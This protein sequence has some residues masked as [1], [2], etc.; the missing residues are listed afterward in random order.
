[1]VAGALNITRVPADGALI[2]GNTSLLGSESVREVASNYVINATDISEAFY[3]KGKKYKLLKVLGK[4]PWQTGNESIDPEH[5]LRNIKLEVDPRG[6]RKV[7]NLFKIKR[8]KKYPNYVRKQRQIYREDLKKYQ[9]KHA[10]SAKAVAE[11]RDQPVFANFPS[12]TRPPATATPRGARVV[13][14]AAPRVVSTA[15]PRVVPKAAPR[16]ISSTPPRVV[17]KAAPRVGSTA[18]PRGGRVITAASVNKPG[19]ASPHQQSLQTSEKQDKPRILVAAPSPH[20]GRVVSTVTPNGYHYTTKSSFVDVQFGS[21]RHVYSTTHVPPAAQHSTLAPFHHA[22]AQHHSTTLAPIK[23]AAS[24]PQ[25]LSTL[26]PL[27]LAPSAHHHAPTPAPHPAHHSTTLAPLHVPQHHTTASPSHVP[28]H[29]S[30]GPAN[31]HST[32][33]A[34]MHVSHHDSIAPKQVHPSHLS[35]TH[36]PSP[37]STPAS[38]QPTTYHSKIV[39]LK[40]K[41]KEPPALPPYHPPTSIKKS[42]AVTKTVTTA[43]TTTLSTTETIVHSLPSNNKKLP[44]TYGSAS[45]TVHSLPPAPQVSP[46]LIISTSAPL[47]AQPEHTV[48]A[49]GPTTTVH[50]L[51]RLHH[52]SNTRSPSIAIGSKQH[53]DNLFLE[54]DQG[55]IKSLY[56][57][58]RNI[59]LVGPIAVRATGPKT[60]TI[61]DPQSLEHHHNI[62]KR[63]HKHS[64]NSLPAEKPKLTKRPSLHFEPLAKVRFEHPAR[65]DS[66]AKPVI[67]T[68]PKLGNKW[69]NDGVI[70]VLDGNRRWPKVKPTPRSSKL[71]LPTPRV[72]IGVDPRHSKH[73]RFEDLSKDGA[74]DSSSTFVRFPS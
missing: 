64:S 2:G 58:N 30:I 19:P 4:E 41:S 31:F 56:D 48:T 57:E 14:T 5:V 17:T 6:N 63:E 68:T 15:A 61:V 50:S 35:T 12:S 24:T 44:A 11:S 25:H 45:P 70:R 27:H 52:H 36:A 8:R 28:K 34:S 49:A 46:Q 59:K 21:T 7:P 16:E 1:M 67:A 18:A 74:R 40:S 32:T 73:V 13:T 54:L 9:Q 51:P 10:A 42:K 43:T 53:I 3:N 23:H 22:P 66:T 29:T 71:P 47:R 39:L 38:S 62:P 72:D 55:T 65:I 37:L 20:V 33:L 26:A 60:F 69:G